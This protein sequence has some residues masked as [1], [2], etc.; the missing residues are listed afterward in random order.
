MLVV[1]TLTRHDLL[2]RMLGTVDGAVQH[3]V[4]IDNSGRGIDL[5]DGPWEEST[6]LIMPSNLGVAASWN[7]AL[8]M[9]HREP[10]VMIASDDMWWPEGAMDRF[11][12][13][14]SEDRVVVSSTWPHWCAFTIGM[15]VVHQI[16]DFD[17]G[18]YPAYFEDTEYKRR[19]DRADI[20]WVK[21]PEVYHQNSSTLNT[22]GRSWRGGS[23]HK[24]EALFKSGE[25]RGFDPYRWRDQAW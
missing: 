19:M 2:E 21:G 1:P 3:L 8:K 7:L 4:V 22:P 11:A 16:G 24:N 9:A 6:L 14:S 15:G 10:W 20:G 12:E 13:E 17:E 23:Y 25:R 5:P 18:Y